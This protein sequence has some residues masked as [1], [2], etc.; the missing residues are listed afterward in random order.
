VVVGETGM[1]CKR[2]RVCVCGG[3]GRGGAWVGG[4][5]CLGRGV[6]GTMMQEGWLNEWMV[7]SEAG[8][9]VASLAPSHVWFHITAPLPHTWALAS[10][11]VAAVPTL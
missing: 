8:V 10:P 11:L 4:R 1:G 5:A 9:W 3:G 6:E 2:V 7:D